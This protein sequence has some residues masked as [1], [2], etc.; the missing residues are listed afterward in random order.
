M[1]LIS[2][3]NWKTVKFNKKYKLHEKW[4]TNNKL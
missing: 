2:S 1:M 3:V 4:Y